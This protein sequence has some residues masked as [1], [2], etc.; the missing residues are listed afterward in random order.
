MTLRSGASGIRGGFLH[1]DVN[2][3]HCVMLDLVKSGL[4]VDNKESSSKNGNQDRDNDGVN[5][6]TSL[7]VGFN[8]LLTLSGLL[9]PE[10]V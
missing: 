5:L 6:G 9:S 1:G 8:S 2:L 3:E 7:L 10:N 4:Q